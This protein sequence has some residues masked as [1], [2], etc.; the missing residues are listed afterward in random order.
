[1]T[2]DDQ[3]QETFPIPTVPDEFFDEF[4][5]LLKQLETVNERA[6]LK[7]RK[8]YSFLDKF[9]DFVSTFTVCGKGCS[10]CCKIGVGITDLEAKMI[11]ETT[12]RV[13]K[14][15]KT[16]AAHADP[17]PCPFL[18]ASGA[19]TIYSCR[20]FNC[21]TL[22]TLDDPEFCR[23]GEPHFIYGSSDGQYSVYF[24]AK[25]NEVLVRLNGRKPVYDIRDLFG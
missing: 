8:I 20:P 6:T 3:A 13:R 10:H 9:S 24:Y 4:T 22:Y 16:G 1:M 14:Q 2:T 19:C 15:P 25:L 18:D 21:R 17:T 12:G 5:V 23:T 7:L 11:E